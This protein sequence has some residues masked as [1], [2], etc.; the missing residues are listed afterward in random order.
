M[1]SVDNSII[2]GKT[3]TNPSVDG[4]N[5]TK[6]MAAVIT[7]RTGQA[8]IT[9]TRFYYYPAG[10]IALIT[11]SHCDDLLL[12]TNLGSDTFIKNL[13]FTGV[14]GKYLLMIGLK[15]DVIYDLD[16]SLS[17]AF[18]GGDRSSATIVSNFAHI[19]TSNNNACLQ[20]STPSVWDDAYMC[21]QTVTIRRVFFTNLIDPYVFSTQFMKVMEISSIEEVVDPELSSDLYTAVKS[22]QG[23]M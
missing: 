8:N 20:S 12:Y 13:T 1:V 6:G 18:D 19:G 17:D 5:Y 22:L 10:S 9:N 11:C 14:V 4:S 2:V 23:T 15:R 7:P 21:D 16:G 3:V